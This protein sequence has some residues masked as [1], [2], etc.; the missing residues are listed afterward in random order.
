MNS[1]YPGVPGLFRELIIDHIQEET[2]NF[3]TFFFRDGHGLQ[4]EAGQFITLIDFTGIQEIRRSY[5]IV[6]SPVLQEPLAIGVKRLENGFF[7]RN[8]IDRARTGDR[9]ITTGVSGFFRLPDHMKAFKSFFFFAAGSG[10][11]PILSLVKTILHVYP[12]KKVC[13]MYSSRSV[14]DTAYYQYLKKIQ[15]RFPEQLTLNFL[16]STA[17]NLLKAR[18]NRELL[19]EIL[20]YNAADIEKTFF[21]TCGPESYMRL[22]IFLLLERGFPRDHIKKEDFNPGNKKIILR[23]PPDKNSYRIQ[24]KLGDKKT[25]FLVQYP[26]TI[27]QAAKRINLLLPYSCESGKCGTCVARCISGKVWHS[28]NEVLTDLDLSKGLILTCTGHPQSENLSL[29]IDS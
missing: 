4:F 11:T 2:R 19:L 20:K 18:L 7:S 24:L 9:L 8:L 13:L 25:N 6:S 3:K 16:F 12:D 15:L 29:E 21:Y 23:R 27:L 17:A 10:I 28:N 14:E 22:V 26:D 1:S 5:S